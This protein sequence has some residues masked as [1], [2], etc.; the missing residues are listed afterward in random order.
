MRSQRF[1]RVGWATAAATV[2]VVAAVALLGFAL[3]GLPGQGGRL[4]PQAVSGAAPSASLTTHGV[5]PAPPQSY[6]RPADESRPFV[7]ASEPRLLEAPDI[8]LK[9]AVTPYTPEQVEANAGAVKPSS[10]WQVAWWTGG[11]A[12]G[13]PGDNTV[14]LYGHTW[15][16]PA[17]FND[18]K[19]LEP[20]DAVYVTTRTGRLHYVVESSFTVAKSDLTKTPTVAAAIPG[21]LLLLGCY[22][23]TGREESTTRNVV[24]IAHLA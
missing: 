15:K 17:V 4:D 22:R 8:R 10:L 21:R 23:E 3:F 7:P 12:P 24:V 13:S 6:S 2:L 16:E 18:I 11:G 5:A 19:K 9:A 20:G 1:R 14:Y